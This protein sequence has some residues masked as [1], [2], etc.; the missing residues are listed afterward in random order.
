[1]KNIKLYLHDIFFDS[2]KNNY[3]FTLGDTTNSIVV[4]DSTSFNNSNQNLNLNNESLQ[5]TTKDTVFPSIDVN[6]E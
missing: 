5:D 1:M 2:D 4:D 3:D 6:L